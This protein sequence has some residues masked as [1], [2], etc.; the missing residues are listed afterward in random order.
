ML[1]INLFS[2]GSF[3][4]VTFSDGWRKNLWILSSWSTTPIVKVH[5]YR[6][7]L[8]G[9]NTNARHSLRG[10]SFSS[11]FI[12]CAVNAS[13]LI[14]EPIT[15]N[16]SHLNLLSQGFLIEHWQMCSQQMGLGK[17]ASG[18]FVCVRIIVC[19][20]KCVSQIFI[21]VV[22]GQ[23]WKLYILGTS[24]HGRWQVVCGGSVWFSQHSREI[25]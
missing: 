9:T 4:D 21:S 18:V 11:I 10:W 20:R 15:H 7:C 1:T 12:C 5:K 14:K 13:S 19:P 6:L 25:I 16:G 23:F 8:S 24:P 22:T 17:P 2:L 3:H